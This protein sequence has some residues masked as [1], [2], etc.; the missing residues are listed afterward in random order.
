LLIKSMKADD[1]TAIMRSYESK[2]FAY[3]GRFLIPLAV[4][5]DYSYPEITEETVALSARLYDYFH[6]QAHRVFK[7]LSGSHQTGMSEAQQRL[8]DA[9]PAKF[10]TEEAVNISKSLNLSDKFFHVNFKRVYERQGWIAKTARGTYQK[11]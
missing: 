8:F 11:D 9:L 6:A 10:S 7:A 2:L 3:Q 4:I 1:A 5:K